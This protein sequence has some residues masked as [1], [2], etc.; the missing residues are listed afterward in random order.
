MGRIAR[1]SLPECFAYSG[2]KSSQRLC[3]PPTFH[4]ARITE[5]PDGF[6]EKPPRISRLIS[7]LPGG[8]NPP[9]TP[10]P[11]KSLPRL[12]TFG[13]LCK[14]HFPPSRASSEGVTF[15]RDVCLITWN[16]L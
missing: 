12:H 7:H 11:P 8:S 1:T 15:L 5:A 6:L 14:R 13:R 4:F 16:H 10:L 9:C 2:S 3:L